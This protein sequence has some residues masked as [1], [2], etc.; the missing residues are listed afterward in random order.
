MVSPRELEED[1]NVFIAKH[2]LDVTKVGAQQGFVTFLTKCGSY[3]DPSGMGLHLDTD[4]VK[5]QEAKEAIN[6]F[7]FQYRD[8]ITR[9]V[10]E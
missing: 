8:A 4:L 9:P 2:V 10:Q 3:R 5:R 6:Y 7:L 1:G